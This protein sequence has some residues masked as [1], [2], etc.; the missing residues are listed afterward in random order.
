MV[1]VILTAVNWIAVNW[2][3]VSIFYEATYINLSTNKAVQSFLAFLLSYPFLFLK[4]INPPTYALWFDLH[5]NAA[6]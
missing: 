4:P 5:G 2:S 6:F 1:E 3:Y